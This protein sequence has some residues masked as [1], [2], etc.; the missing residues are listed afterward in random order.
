MIDYFYYK[1]YKASLKSSLNDIPEYA[2]PIWLGGLIGINLL[3]V[4]L[5]LVKL[6][7]LPN[8]IAD[9]RQGGAAIAVLICTCLIVYNKK[10][11]QIV[12]ERFMTE[13]KG[14]RIKGNILV[15]TYIIV[16]FLLIFAVAF[17]KP[18]KL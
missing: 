3:V 10:R 13:S 18:G 8:I 17:F 4:Y 2:A 6:D 16:S 1:L 5:F 14:R 11:R 7:L 12:L 9:K 15:F